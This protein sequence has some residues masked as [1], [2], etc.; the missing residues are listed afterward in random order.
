MAPGVT[1]EFL[2]QYFGHVSDVLEEVGFRVVAP[3]PITTAIVV[4]GL[5]TEAGLRGYDNLPSDFTYFSEIE[6]FS[7]LQFAGFRWL[8]P[9]KKDALAGSAVIFL[10]QADNL[11]VERCLRDGGLCFLGRWLR[12][13]RYDPGRRR[14]APKP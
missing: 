6:R 9:P 11:E 3:L 12:A 8:V 1:T 14:R 10:P 2:L 5:P 7:G 13:V 4:H